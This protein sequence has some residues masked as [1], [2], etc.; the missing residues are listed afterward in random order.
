MN[1]QVLLIDDDPIFH[2]IFT[3]M[4]QKV[5]A[6][7]KVTSYLNGKI[8]LDHLNK[9]YTSNNQYIILLDINMPVINGWQFLH[10]IKKSGIIKNNNLTLYIVSSSTDI[11]DIKQAQSHDLVKSIFSKP[12]SINSIKHILQS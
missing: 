7:L 1:K 10:E 11:D 6:Q 2:V 4:I 12:L 9:N 8:A 3:R 5:C